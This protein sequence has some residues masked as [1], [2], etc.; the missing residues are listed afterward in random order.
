MPASI[1]NSAKNSARTG[2]HFYNNSSG[3]FGN[4]KKSSI[5][6]AIM[7]LEESPLREMRDTSKDSLPQLNMKVRIN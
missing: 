5:K 2:Q 6:P 7:R 4:R 3:T 1:N